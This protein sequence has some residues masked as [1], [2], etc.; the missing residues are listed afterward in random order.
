MGALVPAGVLP[1]PTRNPNDTFTIYD[2]AAEGVHGQFNYTSRWGLRQPL[3]TLRP[4]GMRG[5][6]GQLLGHRRVP[7]GVL[8]LAQARSVGQGNGCGFPGITRRARPKWFYIGN[9]TPAAALTRRGQAGH[10]IYA[11]G[12]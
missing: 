10:G 2:T 9:S 6:H 1:A 3:R 12:R 7:H 11:N 8:R 4:G 5:Q